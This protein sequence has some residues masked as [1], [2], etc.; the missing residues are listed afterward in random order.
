MKW[1][2]TEE[3]EAETAGF[4]GTAQYHYNPLYK[5]MKYTDGVQF[6]GANGFAWLIDEIAFNFHNLMAKGQRGLYIIVLET[7]GNRADLS[8]CVDLDGET[9]I[10][11]LTTKKITYTD[12]P[13]GKLKLYWQDGVLFLPSEY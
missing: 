7:K 12:A 13:Q 1:K 5:Y 6:L 8:V 3:L 11:I 2:T 9:M 10:D 4:Y